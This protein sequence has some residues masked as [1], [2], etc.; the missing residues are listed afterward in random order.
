MA[1]KLHS[2]ILVARL[3]YEQ[4]KQK[5][6]GE[7]AMLA[8]LLA[9][10]GGDSKLADEAA[11]L[12][13]R[14]APKRGETY[15]VLMQVALARPD[16]SAAHK[17][18]AK[19]YEFGGAQTVAIGI[20]GPVDPWFAY[21]VV[22]PLARAHPKDGA[23]QLVFARTALVAGDEGAALAAARDSHGFE[24]GNR[25]AGFIEVQSLWA[26]GRH[27]AALTQAARMQAANPHDVSFSVF[28]AN[29]LARAGKNVEARGVLSDARA[30]EP[31]DPE[32]ALGYAMLAVEAGDLAEARR[33]FTAILENGGGSSAVYN[34]LG[35]LAEEKNDWGEA[36]G[37]Y[38]AI[39]SPDDLATSRVSS[40]FALARWRGDQQ[41]EAYL[42]HLEQAFPGLT[43]TW[44]GVR[45]TL[46]D[47]AGKREAAWKYL[48]ET[49]ERY[50][51]VRPLRYQRALLADGLGKGADALADLK[52]LVRAEPQ[53]PMYLNAYGY[54]LTEHTKRYHEAYGY[55]KRALAINPDDGATLDSM[56]WVL[57]RLGESKKA[58]AYL[59]RA[60]KTT[61][62]IDVARHLVI[63]YLALNRRSEAKRVLS[64]ALAKSPKNHALLQLQRRLAQQ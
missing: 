37:W 43:P 25:A 8:A 7:H 3:L 36:F 45:A 19:A 4:A 15:A 61:G 27:E 18:A 51:M 30:L 21:A 50:P 16:L 42:S 20:D 2:P 38:Q 13:K 34:M 60:W 41:A 33:Q 5:K 39:G 55:I 22:A 58:I 32:V 10:R 40:L 28:Y 63:V 53:N 23:M 11:A 52:R 12:A 17:A 6:D 24:P 44:A 46:L 14:L 1:S 9:L 56:G 35:Q 29:L 31:D 59:R 54:T 26:L 49:L 57:Y 62:D 47:Q 64:E 48:G